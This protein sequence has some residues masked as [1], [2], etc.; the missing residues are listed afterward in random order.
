MRFMS[1]LFE[2]MTADQI[3]LKTVDEISLELDL[4][5]NETRKILVSLEREGVIYRRRGIIGIRD[6]LLK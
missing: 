3:L 4:T 6:E 1:Y 5:Y 2:H